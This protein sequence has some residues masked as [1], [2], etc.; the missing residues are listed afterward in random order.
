M[1]DKSR[2]IFGG[3]LFMAKYTYEQTLKAAMDVTKKHMSCEAVGK[4]N[5]KK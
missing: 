5:L 2:L 4:L 3:V 1:L